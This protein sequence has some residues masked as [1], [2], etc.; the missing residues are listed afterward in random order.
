[1]MKIFKTILFIV[2]QTL[3][4]RTLLPQKTFHNNRDISDDEME[5]IFPQTPLQNLM[6]KV[7]RVLPLP[8]MAFPA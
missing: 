8:R 1:M 7:D 2:S 3:V 4:L 5:F 6:K